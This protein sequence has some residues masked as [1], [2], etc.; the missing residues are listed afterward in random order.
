MEEPTMSCMYCGGPDHPVLRYTERR[1][2][3]Y[4]HAALELHTGH[5]LTV[6]QGIAGVTLFCN[7]CHRNVI[8]A[9]AA[10]RWRGEYSMPHCRAT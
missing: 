6:N 9:G 5:A 4:I 7:D 3:T 10:G 1:H 2:G 8:E